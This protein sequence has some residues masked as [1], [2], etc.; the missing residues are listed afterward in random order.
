MSTRL[1]LLAPMRFCDS[2]DSVWKATFMP[3]RN[4]I[5]MEMWA[6]V[7]S[8]SIFFLEMGV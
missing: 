3:Q 2:F 5:L 8:L 1:A 4:H 6:P 7:M